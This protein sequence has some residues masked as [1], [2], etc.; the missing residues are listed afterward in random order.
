MKLLTSMRNICEAFDSLA[1]WFGL[2]DLGFAD[3]GKL[4]VSLVSSLLMLVCPCALGVWLP[5]PLSSASPPPSS[6][7]DW[8]A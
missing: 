6:S 8:V 5:S 7:Y 3:L 1:I 2:G 4:M